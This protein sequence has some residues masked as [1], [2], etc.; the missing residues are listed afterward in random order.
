[1][2]RN[3]EPAYFA[4][5]LQSIAPMSTVPL[6]F[7]K[8][9]D[10]PPALVIL[11]GLFGSSD[12]WH[13]L[14]RKWSE[15][16]TVYALDLRN[17]G[18]SPHTDEFSYALM[19]ED[20]LAWMHR[21]NLD[22]AFFLGHSMGG[23][24]AMQ[25]ALQHPEKVQGLIVAD[26][27]PDAYDDTHNLMHHTVFRAFEVLDPTTIRRRSE[28]EAV[29]RNI[30]PSAGVR[31]FLLKNL[32]RTP[33][34]HYR[35]KPHWKALKKHYHRILEAVEG[36]PYPGPALFLKGALSPYIQPHHIAG[37]RRLFPRAEIKEV[38]EAG[39]WVHADRPDLV[40]EWVRNFVLT[41]SAKQ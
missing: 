2:Q 22:K 29:L 14:A 36:P 6:F 34:G 26:I 4:P 31:Q 18:Q 38:P 28:G 32:E 24:V 17:H 40:Y 11:H 33:D 9:G 19:A 5:P 16:F 8:Y 15:D 25:L 23:K 10:R 7:R 35:W 1:M 12:N 27:A 3:K 30:I 41:H 37:I 20:V 21:E 39:H 13:T